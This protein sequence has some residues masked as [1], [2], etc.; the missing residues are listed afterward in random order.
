[1]LSLRVGSD[2]DV[3]V[4]RRVFD[5]DDDGIAVVR[6]R[7]ARDETECGN[8]ED[9]GKSSRASLP[10]PRCAIAES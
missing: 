9:Q 1:M 4:G 3:E 8:A 6:H 7:G 2:P 10:S 5:I